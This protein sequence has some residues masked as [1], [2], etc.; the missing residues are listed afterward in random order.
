MKAYIAQAIKASTEN[1]HVVVNLEKTKMELTEAEKKLKWV[2]S[3]AESSDKECEQNQKRILEL[4]MELDRERCVLFFGLLL[5]VSWVFDISDWTCKQNKFLRS[6]RKKLEEEYE[7]IKNEVMEMS[8]ESEEATIQKLQD[9][10][11]EC[12]A[13]L[14][15]GVCFDRPKEVI[16]L[17]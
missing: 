14:K 4:R 1:I 17:P 12:K 7:E 11:K 13:I 16:T 2:K 6:E 8:N 10:I 15:C 3:A 5:L 9:E